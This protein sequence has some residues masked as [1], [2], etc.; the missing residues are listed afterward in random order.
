MILL[1]L[2]S[3]WYQPY[4]NI[5]PDS[6]VESLKKAGREVD[7]TRLPRIQAKLLRD[8]LEWMSRGYSD[9]QME[10]MV[11]VVLQLGIEK[12]EKR[13]DEKDLTPEI[14]AR[15]ESFLV[16][17]PLE[18]ERR[19]KRCENMKDYELKFYY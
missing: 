3:L 9:R 13:L 2:L 6:T 15:I 19:R 4:F 11:A 18:I 14:K 17:A 12:A 16:L 5:M 10:F 1:L 8:D 7:V